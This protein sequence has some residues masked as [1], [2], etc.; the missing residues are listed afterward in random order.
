MPAG[1]YFLYAKISPDDDDAAD[2]AGARGYYTEYMKCGM[3]AGCGSKERIILDV[4]AG[5][6]LS[7]ILVGDF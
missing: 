2:L 4:Q 3:E 5:K 6:T 7:N 1:R